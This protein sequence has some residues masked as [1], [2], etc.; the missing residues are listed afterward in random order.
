MTEPDGP[1][2]RRASVER[3]VTTAGRALGVDL[4]GRRIGLALSD[5]GRTIASPL[6][7]LVRGNNPVGDRAAILGV[8]REHEA[9]VVVVGWPRSLSGRDGPAARAARVEADALA[10]AAPDGL[11]VVLHDERLTTVQAERSLN[12]AGMRRDRQ[13]AVVDKVAAAVMLQSFLDSEQR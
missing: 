11:A 9:T 3:T 4:G 6:T 2:R 8:A 12:E 7:V 10:A 5:P 1:T 13:R